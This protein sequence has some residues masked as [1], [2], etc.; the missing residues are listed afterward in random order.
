MV[1]TIDDKIISLLPVDYPKWGNPDTSMAFPFVL[2]RLSASGI[3]A[4]FLSC[5]IIL[6]RV[7]LSLIFWKSFLNSSEK[8]ISIVSFH[9]QVVNFFFTHLHVCL[10]KF[11]SFNLLFT[12]VYPF[13]E[14]HIFSQCFL[15]DHF[16]QN[17]P[18]F[19]KNQKLCRWAYSCIFSYLGRYNH[20]AVFRHFC[21]C[22][23][24]GLIM[25]NDTNI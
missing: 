20:L 8:I 4:S 11:S 3:S 1:K 2:Q 24:H 23:F 22:Y 19:I 25:A 6:N 10:G 12:S 7:I 13:E 21:Y 17:I 15:A 16:K 5:L 14:M 18:A 9:Q